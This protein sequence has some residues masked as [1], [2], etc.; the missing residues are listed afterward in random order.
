MIL[1]DI[2]EEV[3]R[4]L[5]F[6][7]IAPS[8]PVRSYR[9]IKP[10]SFDKLRS[11]IAN[12]LVRAGANEV[13]TYSFVHGNLLEKA[14]QS[15][16]YSYKIVNSISPELQ[17][18]RQS[19][20]PSLLQLVHA[21]S[22]AGFDDFALF[23]YNKT[24]SKLHGLT[25][26]KVPQEMYMLAGVVARKKEMP[27][28]PY[29]LAKTYL[30][31][32]ATS[33]GTTFTYHPI[34]KKLDYPVTAPFEYRR[35]AL[36]GDKK[37]G[38]SLGIIGEYTTQVT[39]NFKLPHYVAGF[40]IDPRVLEKIDT[41]VG[42]YEPLSRYPGVERDICFK[43][44]AQTTYSD[45][46]KVVDSVLAKEGLLYVLVPLDIYSPDSSHKHI[47]LRMELTSYHKTL[48]GEEVAQIEA[49]IAQASQA[50]LEAEI[51]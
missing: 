34:T 30:D 2:V 45:L 21:N 19:L 6:D 25:S 35:S 38:E 40:E 32:I 10:S 39:R 5:G 29:Y 46:Y 7:T 27:G 36:V 23:E 16:E 48:T 11:R 8:L 15:P 12:T 3:G 44:R 51:I 1:E 13:L 42:S 37:T 33:L 4:I 41:Q 20:T 47:T 9:A 28:A 22:K 26:E 43:V 49:R 18:Y 24:H 50:T 17:Y 31:Y 14:G